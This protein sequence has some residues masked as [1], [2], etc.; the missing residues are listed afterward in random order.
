M[1]LLTAAV[2]A[3]SPPPLAAVRVAKGFK[4]PTY[5]CAAP[6]DT[7]RLFVLEKETG[8]IRIIK[9]GVVLP[10]PFLDIRGKLGKELTLEQGLW[11]MAFPPDFGPDNNCFYITHSDKSG[12]GVLE[13][14]KVGSNPDRAKRRS[15]KVLLRIEQDTSIHYSGTIAF[16]PDGML[17]MSRGDAG[18]FYDPY[19]HAQDLSLLYGKILR[20]SVDKSKPYTI[21]PD[22]PFVGV[23]GARPE[24]WDYGFRNPWRFS[25][26]P[27]TGDLYIGDVGQHT[28]EEIDVEPAG[29]G[30]G[31][32]Y[33][34]P[35]LEAD[36]CPRGATPCDIPPGV[37]MPVHVY[38]RATGQAVIGGYVY[39]GAAMPEWQGAYFF[40]DLITSRIWS[41][42]YVNGAA[43]ELIEHTDELEPK[44]KPTI[45]LISSWGL[46]AE[47]EMYIC[48]YLDGEIY[49]IVPGT[50]K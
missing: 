42:R 40:A 16:G 4:N 3:D 35:M 7:S 25:F 2:L 21:P 50:K 37:T 29:S 11:C 8:Q 12:A 23:P 34:W 22:N 47:G 46:D 27:V 26:D 39:R 15:A 14:Y 19:G 6:G 38:P 5:L 18:P 33:G 30:G 28:K 31:L 32:N 41:F 36:G 1:L 24:I 20:I 48:D 10:E 17:Y 45:N 13:V 44:G 49:K 43:T 9:D